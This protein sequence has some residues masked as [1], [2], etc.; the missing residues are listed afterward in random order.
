VS[1]HSKWSTIKHKKAATDAK[2]SKAFTQ[3]ANLIAIAARQGGGDPKMNFA[4]RLAIDKG[5]AIN[6]PTAN[7]ERAIKRG[8]GEGGGAR[9]E[10]VLYEGYGPSGIAVLVEAAT[11]NKNRTVADIR[12]AFN[13]YGG[14]LGGAGSVAYLFDHKGKLDIELKKQSLGKEDVELIILDSG[15]DDFEENEET[16]AVFT[17][18]NEL[19]RVKDFLENMDIKEIAGELIYDPQ[20]T[21][22]VKDKDKA[23]SIIKLMDALEESDDVMAVHSNFDIPEEILEEL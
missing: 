8:T 7:I 18:A 19:S 1:G 20:K 15:A 16:I 3:V 14:S 10:E 13:K 2:K 5:K 22:A 17:K 9:I 4:L 6:M 12:A 23:K 21:V 11:D